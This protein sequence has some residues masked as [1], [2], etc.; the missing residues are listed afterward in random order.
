MLYIHHIINITRNINPSLPTT[1]NI[2]IFL[3][4]KEM[5]NI[6]YYFLV[7]KLYNPYIVYAMKYKIVNSF[8]RLIFFQQ[9]AVKD[10]RETWE[11]L[12]E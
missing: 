4:L 11:N 8:Q 10:L 3:R 9:L 6:I 5:Y 12:N 7:L 2:L 1:H